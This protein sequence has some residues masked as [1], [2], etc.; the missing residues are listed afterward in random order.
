MRFAFLL[1]V[2][3]L[4]L[5]FSACE[6]GEVVNLGGDAGHSADDANARPSSPPDDSGFDDGPYGDVSVF[7]SPFGDAGVP[8]QT[9][10]PLPST[11][12]PSSAADGWILFDSDAVDLVPHVFAIRPDGSGL[13]QITS[14]TSPDTQ[15][16]VSFDGKT[17][18]FTSTR[19]GAA[20][21][22]S[23]D[24]AS[25]TVTQLTST[26][27]G[28]DE[29][30]FSPD[31]KTIAFHSVYDTW[32]MNADGSSAHKVILTDPQVIGGG[33]DY[34]YPVFMQ[35][36]TQIIVDR[37][38]EVDAFD[39]SGNQ[40]RYVVGNTTAEEIQPALS[41]DGVNIAFVADSCDYGVADGV[42]LLA[43]ASGTLPDRCNGR[44]ATLENLGHLS[45]PSW[46]PGTLITFAHVSSIGLKRIVVSDAAKL[47]GQPVE[48][49]QDNGNQE[50][51][52]WAPSTFSPPA[53]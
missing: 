17:I 1:S 10:I 46:G 35:N 28:A 7:P 20:E 25:K 32:V 26:S 19:T 30:A 43:N 4:T 13:T 31:G 37:L 6:S 41:R 52:T 21:I 14:G 51:P 48:L 50:N 23:F 24:V 3:S 9:S 18:A 16:T 27:D 42:I 5:A 29:A 34:E 49:L 47:M 8:S 45:H 2:S 40:L 38:N 15:P 36:G 53:P 39:L 44:P 12:G 11:G 33:S 22:F